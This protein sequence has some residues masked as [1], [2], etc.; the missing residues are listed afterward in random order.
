MARRSPARYLAPLALVAF[1]VA[2][3]LVV[4]ASPA[5][6]GAETTVVPTPSASGKSASSSSKSRGAG[7][8]KRRKTYTVKPGDTP[9]AIAGRAGIP[10]SRL[11]ELNP[12]LD[13]QSLA[14]GQKLRLRR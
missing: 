14:P 8:K 9:S 10:L 6:D 7:R 2:L 11:L 5:G 4:S 1:A 12:D 13:P 3:V